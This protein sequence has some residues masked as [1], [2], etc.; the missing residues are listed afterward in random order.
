MRIIKGSSLQPCATSLALKSGLGVKTQVCQQFCD[1][2]D[3]YLIVN[4]I[5]L[6]QYLSSTWLVELDP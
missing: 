4:N 1:F 5:I 6:S 3:I 2:A